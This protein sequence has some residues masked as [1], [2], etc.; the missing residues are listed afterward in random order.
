MNAAF[1][2][3]HE[4][5]IPVVNQPMHKVV[6]PDPDVHIFSISHPSHVELI[7]SP[8][9]S[10]EDKAH[11]HHS[12][13]DVKSP[14]KADFGHGGHGGHNDADSKEHKRDAEEGEPVLKKAHEAPTI[15]LF[16]DLFFVA[17]LTVRPFT[18]PSPNLYPKVP[19]NETWQ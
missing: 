16:F 18:M 1:N 8:L 2:V 15:Q 11:G 13:P 3:F 5:P 17:N 12:H 7:S 14:L 4:V 9:A 19:P 6:V 10:E